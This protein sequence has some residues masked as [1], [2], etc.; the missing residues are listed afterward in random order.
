MTRH[1]ETL[2]NRVESP[3]CR[4]YYK[5]ILAGDL[6]V[7]QPYTSIMELPRLEKIVLN[8]TSKT[9][10]LDKKNVI[11]AQ[12]ALELLS[13]QRAATTRA[14]KSIATF[15]IR[16]DQILGARVTLRREPMATFLY[17]L[18]HTVL[19]RVGD[20]ETLGAKR[21]NTLLRPGQRRPAR[22]D[23]SRGIENWMV[24]P[25]LQHHFELFET[26]RGLQFTM[27]FK[28]PRLGD[29]ELLTTALQLPIKGT[30][31]NAT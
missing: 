25:E 2:E 30:S 16:Q 31:K 5:H 10:A 27:V 20:L 28:T 24:F 4:K 3:L 12:I 23:L 9:F 19:P 1:P 6:L 21:R 22:T 15:K 11:P 17:K 7:K 14:A 29:F 18:I 13:G 8:T 26:L